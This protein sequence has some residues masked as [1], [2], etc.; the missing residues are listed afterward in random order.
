MAGAYLP[1]NTHDGNYNTWYSVK[2]GAVEGNFLKLYLTQTCNVGEVVFV[3]RRGGDFRERM[4]NTEVKVYS[5]RGGGESQVAS[6][7][8]I[9]GTF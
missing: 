4:L 6:C 9:T 1:S 7:G 2:D 3:C 5:T 8:I